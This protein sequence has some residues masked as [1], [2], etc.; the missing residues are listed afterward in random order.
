MKNFYKYLILIF[1]GILIFLLLN[2]RDS[3]SVG[4][5]AIWID[6]STL[7][8][9]LGITPIHYTTG[10]VVNP[11]IIFFNPAE[12]DLTVLEGQNYIMF[13]E[14]QRDNILAGLLG[15][16]HYDII[17]TILTQLQPNSDGLYTLFFNR[18]QDEQQ[19]GLGLPPHGSGPLL[20]GASSG[21][22]DVDLMLQHVSLI[23]RL[24]RFFRSIG[25]SRLARTCAS[26]SPSPAQPPCFPFLDLPPE[27]LEPTLELMSIEQL[28]IVSET[29]RQ[30]RDLAFQ[31]IIQKFDS[32]DLT[33]LERDLILSG[34]D[35]DYIKDKPENALLFIFSYEFLFNKSVN[36]LF[37]LP[38]ATHD[39][40]TST[41]TGDRQAARLNAL[42]QRDILNEIT[43]YTKCIIGFEL[44]GIG[45]AL[46]HLRPNPIKFVLIK[47]GD[48]YKLVLL[49]R[50]DGELFSSLDDRRAKINFMTYLR[51]EDHLIVTEDIKDILAKI[52]DI[53]YMFSRP[54]DVD[55]T[56]PSTREAI[57]EFMHDYLGL[58]ISVDLLT[59]LVINIV[60][61]LYTH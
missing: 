55:P 7:P 47:E 46:D 50:E 1:I 22:V 5:P 33:P 26:P 45:P 6:P 44:S 16:P 35:F 8:E 15:H 28:I 14:E 41:S 27:I 34:E 24:S 57:G 37:I 51:S 52:A 61:F 4:N 49:S 10:E 32:L 31:I 3:F 58:T 2:S 56:N 40:P 30:L 43:R 18:D 42:L 60:F 39:R 21:P 38:Y 29:C 19:G 53:N 48:V 9:D 36:D 25:L 13:N 11:D 17:H 23:D 20:P 59:N 12:Y 54:G